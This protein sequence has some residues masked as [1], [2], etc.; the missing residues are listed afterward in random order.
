MLLL[1]APESY[2]YTLLEEWLQWA[3]GDNRGSKNFATLEAL[4]RAMSKSG[5]GSAATE[6]RIPHSVDQLL[7]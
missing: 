4:Q 7:L 2:L 6:L 5:L 3:P 1:T